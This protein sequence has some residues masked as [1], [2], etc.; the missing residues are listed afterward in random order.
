VTFRDRIRG[1]LGMT[2]APA[3]VPAQARALGALALEQRTPRNLVWDDF[4]AGSQVVGARSVLA[5]HTVPRGDI[6]EVAVNRPMRAY[7]RALYTVTAASSAGGLV[8]LDLGAASLAMI[9]STRA[10]PTAPFTTGHPDV[11]VYAEET[12]GGTR[13]VRTVAA[14]DFDAGTID[15]SGLTASTSFDFEVYYLSGDGELRIRASQPSGVD[16]RTVELF[17]DTLAALHETDQANGR[18]APRIVRAGLNALPLGPKWT[19]NLEIDSS[20]RFVWTAEAGHELRIQGHR[21]PVSAFDES[22][23]NA[24][25]GQTLLN[26]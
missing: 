25:I 20:A 2:A 14:V 16:E 17:N 21:I 26:G 6:F 5:C 13:A 15:L 9:R 24:L 10:A 18:T 4:T 3:N 7:L 11:I 1:A 22:Q 23:L 12:G 8:T 19:L